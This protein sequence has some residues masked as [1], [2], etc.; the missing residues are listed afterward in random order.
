MAGLKSDIEGRFSALNSLLIQAHN[1][2]YDVRALHQELA[3]V[4]MNYAL[5]ISGCEIQLLLHEGNHAETFDEIA[6][7]I[8]GENYHRRVETLAGRILPAVANNPMLYQLAKSLSESVDIPQTFEVTN[9]YRCPDC[10]TEMS[11][12][13]DTVM[14]NCSQCHRI[15]TIEGTVSCEAQYY[16]QEGQKAKT[17]GFKP[18]K[19]FRQWMAQILGREPD[20]K[21]GDKHDPDNLYGEKVIAQVK[22]QIKKYQRIADLLRVSDIRS[23]LSDINRSD[24]NNHCTQILRRATD[25]VPPEISPDL[26]AYADVLF[27][28]VLQARDQIGTKQINRRYYPFYI[29]KIFEHIIPRG[30][31]AL[32][33]LDF[34]H[35]QGDDT[36]VKCDEEWKQ[37]CNIVPELTWRP[38]IR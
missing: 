18:N 21:I 38:T 27:S 28:Q 30:D 35:M 37:I 4:Q 16:P 1:Y 8:R 5:M 29:Y 24:L 20:T 19:H 33:V 10:N 23:I 22:A 17:G 6:R 12:I 3:A 14:L 26:T 34:I 15:I 25:K 36:I 13:P 9:F 31:P 11:L 32:G 2:G 7:T